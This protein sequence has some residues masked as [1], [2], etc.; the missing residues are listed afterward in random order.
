M[1]TAGAAPALNAGDSFFRVRV[2]TFCR[3][4]TNNYFPEIVSTLDSIQ[5]SDGVPQ[6]VRYSAQHWN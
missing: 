1:H 3:T 2:S 5:T 6:R 4:P